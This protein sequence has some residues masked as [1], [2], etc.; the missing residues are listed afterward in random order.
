MPTLPARRHR[1]RRRYPNLARNGPPTQRL[2]LMHLPMVDRRSPRCAGQ[3]TARHHRSHEANPGR[4]A[5]IRQRSRSRTSMDR[6]TGNGMKYYPLNPRQ[7]ALTCRKLARDLRAEAAMGDGAITLTSADPP[8]YEL[9]SPE[10]GPHGRSTNRQ[11]DGNRKPRQASL[12]APTATRSAASPPAPAGHSPPA[13][14]ARDG[15]PPDPRATP[16]PRPAAAD[17]PN[18]NCAS[19]WATNPVPQPTSHTSIATPA[20]QPPDGRGAADAP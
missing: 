13:P 3:R 12:T 8:G 10:P 7:M 14:D 4:Y 18:P 16:I 9:S 19:C 15:T 2:R 5:A 11:R 17:D 1:P 6:T 20:A